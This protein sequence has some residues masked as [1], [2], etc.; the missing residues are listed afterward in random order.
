MNALVI[1]CC[2]AFLGGALYEAA[3]IGWAHYAQEGRPF[4]TSIFS[5]LCAI[6]QV[7]GIGESVTTWIAAPFFVLGYG[8]GTYG[9]VVFKNHWIKK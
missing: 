4:M 7:A 2:V 5:M 6:S 1:S 8:I 9:A 3:C